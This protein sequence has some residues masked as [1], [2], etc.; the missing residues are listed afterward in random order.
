MKQKSHISNFILYFLSAIFLIS[1]TGSHYAC[2]KQEDD[3]SETSRSSCIEI[4]KSIDFCGET[5]DLTR[6]DR[7][8]RMDRELLAFSYMHSTSIQVLKRANRY[9][10]VIKPIL[11]AHNIPDD[12]IYLMAIE[13]NVDPNARSAAGAAGL[14]QIMPVT[15]KELGLEINQ[16]VDERYHIKKA[17]EAACKYLKQAYE[18]FG[19]WINVAASYNAGQGRISQQSKKQ[20]EE[21]ALDMYLVEETSRYVYRILAAK[22]L[23]QNP[24]AFGFYLKSSDLYPPIPYHKVT[25]NKSIN[26]LAQFAKKHG[27]TYA[28]LRNMNPWI[29]NYSLPVR[30]NEYY[31]IDIPDTKK[32]HYNP[33]MTKSYFSTWTNDTL[34]PKQ[35]Q[36]KPIHFHLYL[37]SHR[38]TN[39][40]PKVLLILFLTP[41]PKNKIPPRRT[42]LPRR[43]A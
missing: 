28:I 32:M 19:N 25:I 27:I 10:P 43:D 17:T 14:W 6:Y 24:Q 8:E 11:K 42:C 5:I 26:D 40:F 29:R 20:Y 37:L 39:N 35:L 33:H 7:R 4:P 36:K 12:F 41:A 34:P 30:E 18:R 9:F 3:Q 38:C 31:I 1:L 15:G 16:Y 21:N 22:I 2:S 23:F 13:S